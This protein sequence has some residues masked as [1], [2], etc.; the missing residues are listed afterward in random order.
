MKSQDEELQRLAEAGELKGNNP[1]S[2]AYIKVF[3][4][5]SKEPSFSLPSSFAQNVIQ[6]IAALEA[7]RETRRDIL[8]LVAG[9]VTFGITTIVCVVL[10]G[11]KF[12]SGAFTFLKNYGGLAFF[13][14]ALAVLFQVLEKKLLP[15]TKKQS[16]I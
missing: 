16:L 8:W 1:D 15:S 5:L 13:G 11:F 7:K 12:D 2:K 4:A 9:V 10:T 14:L 3:D 6:K